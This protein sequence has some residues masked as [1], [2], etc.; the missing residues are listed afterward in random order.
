M[1]RRGSSPATRRG[2]LPP[3][4]PSRRLLRTAGRVQADKVRQRFD[5]VA[6]LQKLT[7]SD[8]R[9][10]QTSGL[11]AYG[12]RPFA[13]DMLVSAPSR[14]RLPTYRAQVCASAR[15]SAGES[16]LISFASSC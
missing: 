12:E 10:D 14:S 4:S 5:A 9:R 3:T 8:L 6:V 7:T 1:R 16:G 2:A 15:R 13:F 11:K